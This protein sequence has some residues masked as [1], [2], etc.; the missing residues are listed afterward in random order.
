MAGADQFRRLPHN[1]I[2]RKVQSGDQGLSYFG[3]GLFENGN[4]KARLGDLLEDSLSGLEK[5]FEIVFDFLGPRSGENGYQ[6]PWPI[7]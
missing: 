5:P 7:R 6:R 2:D 3:L 1:N 4:R